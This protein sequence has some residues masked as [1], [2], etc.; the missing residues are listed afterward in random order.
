MLLA[1]CIP[2]TSDWSCVLF[3]LYGKQQK[4]WKLI[5]CTYR[6]CGNCV[7]HSSHSDN[8]WVLPNEQIK[9]NKICV[10]G[11]KLQSCS[12]NTWTCKLAIFRHSYTCTVEPQY[13]QP[14]YNKVLGITINFL[15]PVI[16][17]YKL[18][19]ITSIEWNLIIA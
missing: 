10:L 11:E 7:N 15:H 9:R 1:I 14:L 6:K 8:S 13:N 19:K 16:V 12:V 2:L 17:N 5:N 18:W 4:F 3:S